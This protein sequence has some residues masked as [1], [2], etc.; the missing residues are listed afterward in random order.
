[1]SRF[2]QARRWAVKNHH[3]KGTL[4]T[5]L[6]VTADEARAALHVIASQ[7]GFLISSVDEYDKK[8]DKF[9][10]AGH[11]SNHPL[12]KMDM[13]VPGEAVAHVVQY[14]RDALGAK[15]LGRASEKRPKLAVVT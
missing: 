15:R 8:K 14:V 1:M 6:D 9:R 7:A 3:A 5:E 4:L 12:R 13:T 2:T 10:L 11:H